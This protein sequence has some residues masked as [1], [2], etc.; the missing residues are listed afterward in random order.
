MNTQKLVQI[1]WVAFI[2][3]GISACLSKKEIQSEEEAY[4]L[5]QP[6]LDFYDKRDF[7]DTLSAS[8]NNFC[9]GVQLDTIPKGAIRKAKTKEY[10]VYNNII[11]SKKQLL[12]KKQ[13]MDANDIKILSFMF[14]HPQQEIHGTFNYS[15]CATEENIKT[16][17]SSEFQRGYR[18]SFL[19][20]YSIQIVISN[21]I[22]ICLDTKQLKILN[23]T[24]SL[25]SFRYYPEIQGSCE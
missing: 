24:D 19:C 8:I 9:I 1:I 4:I 17:S 18:K 11:Y 25:K 6:Y 7:Y 14:R 10:F 16:I 5:I 3:T 22:N 23:I 21:N 2:V 13:L 15:N 20:I 12:G